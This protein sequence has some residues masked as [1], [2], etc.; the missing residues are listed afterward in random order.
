MPR[1]VIQSRFGDYRAALLDAQQAGW[2]QECLTGAAGLDLT[3]KA[4]AE[5]D[6]FWSEEW[7]WL[8]P[9]S[10]KDGVLRVPVR[11]V[12]LNG[13]PYQY[14]GFATGYEYIREAVARGMQDG[15]VHGIAL[16]IHSPGGEVAGNFDLVDRLYGMRGQK[17]I[18]AFAAE[19]AYSAAYSIASAADSITVTRS[20]GVGSIGVVLTHVDYSKALEQA[21]IAVTFI[22]AGK[23]KVDGNP[24]QPL[25]EEVR[26]R[27]QA[28]VDASYDEFVAL[29]ARNRGIEEKAVRDTEALTF[30]SAEAVSNGLADAVGALDDALAAFAAEV[31]NPSKGT[32]MSTKQDAPAVDTAAIENA[33]TEGHTAGR[34]EGHAAGL[35]EGA[36]AERERISAILALDESKDRPKAAFNVALKTAMTVEQAKDFLT[37][38]PTEAKA[39]ET[40]GD[41]PFVVTM[42]NDK[43]PEVGEPGRGEGA[44]SGDDDQTRVQAIMRDYHAHTGAKSKAH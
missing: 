4:S 35:A 10:V 33:R 43:H 22:H 8:R 9:Y 40:K 44:S 28:R 23:H 41:S 37:A 16:V 2:V 25:P 20:G 1:D 24:Y 31:S 11:G 42:N 6:D 3:E 29:V 38:M 36:T 27:F 26:E 18:R 19:Y 14:G 34:A 12:L 13:W 32:T 21:G 30:T 15:N 17:P 5:D 39:E 7:S